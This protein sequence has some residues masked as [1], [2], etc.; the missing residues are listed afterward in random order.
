[1]VIELQIGARNS[2]ILLAGVPKTGRMSLGDGKAFKNV[3]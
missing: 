3:L 1:M 2:V